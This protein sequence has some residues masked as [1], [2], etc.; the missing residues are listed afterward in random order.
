MKNK[1]VLIYDMSLHK[2]YLNN[3]IILSNNKSTL[4]SLLSNFNNLI[5][6]KDINLSQNL[7]TSSC[8]TMNILERYYRC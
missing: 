1:N 5:K 4:E 8:Q 2:I 7:I 6:N 3:K